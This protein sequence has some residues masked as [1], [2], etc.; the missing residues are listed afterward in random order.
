M[1]RILRYGTQTDDRLV[2]RIDDRLDALLGGHQVVER[3]AAVFVEFGG[4]VVERL[5]HGFE[6]AVAR[7]IEPLLGSCGWRSGVIPFFSRVDGP[8]HRSPGNQTEND[9]GQ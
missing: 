4:H 6:L 2:Q 5:G 1:K 8:Q 3:T 7:E 9:P